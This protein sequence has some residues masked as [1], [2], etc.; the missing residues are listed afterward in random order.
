[1]KQLLRR[2]APKITETVRVMPQYLLTQ[3]LQKNA[4]ILNE[5]TIATECVNTY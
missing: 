4:P 3:L 5:T 2:N 1:M